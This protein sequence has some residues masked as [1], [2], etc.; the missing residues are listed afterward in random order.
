[1]FNM[2]SCAIWMDAGQGVDDGDGYV[3]TLSWVHSARM[4]GLYI[5]LWVDGWMDGCTIKTLFFSLCCLPITI[6]RVTFL[7]AGNTK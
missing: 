3:H 1:M 7:D 6:V 4:Y 5:D 2:W